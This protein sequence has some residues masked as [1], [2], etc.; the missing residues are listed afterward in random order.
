MINTEKNNI[1]KVLRYWKI[2]PVI[3]PILP[4][5]GGRYE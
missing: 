4:L 2:I 5:P 3:A 1:G